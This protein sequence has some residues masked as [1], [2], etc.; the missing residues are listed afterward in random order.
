M[1]SK[2]QSN[3]ACLCY[4]LLWAA[5]LTTG[6]KGSIEQ[7][8]RRGALMGNLHAFVEGNWSWVEGNR[9]N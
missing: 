8:Q 5:S 7:R 4:I 1:Y 6:N 9:C 3:V 2:F